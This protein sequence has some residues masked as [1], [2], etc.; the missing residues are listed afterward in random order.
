MTALSTQIQR[1]MLKRFDEDWLEVSRN[2]GDPCHDRN[3]RII[4]IQLIGRNTVPFG[5][6]SGCLMRF[7]E[8]SQYGDRGMR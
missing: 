2:I 4:L 8:Y 7:Q 6:L 5:Q 3:C 1:G